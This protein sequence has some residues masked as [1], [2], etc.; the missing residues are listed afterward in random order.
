VVS[1]VRKERHWAEIT[2]TSSLR[3][4]PN[5]LLEKNDKQHA[6]KTT[7]AEAR[8]NYELVKKKREEVGPLYNVA[9]RSRRVI[10]CQVTLPRA[11]RLPNKGKAGRRFKKT[12]HFAALKGEIRTGESESPDHPR[13]LRQ[14]ICRGEFRQKTVNGANLE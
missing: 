3:G 12:L 5:F 6:E 7:I 8:K 4:Q 14:V 13:L 10:A 1:R 11:V 2:Q 9:E